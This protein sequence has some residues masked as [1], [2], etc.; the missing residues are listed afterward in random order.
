MRAFGGKAESR[1]Q[2]LM[3]VILKDKLIGLYSD[4]PGFTTH[5]VKQHSRQRG[6]ITNE[7]L[8]SV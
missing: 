2:M 1:S 5:T 3:V 6:A 8:T 4:M 7:D